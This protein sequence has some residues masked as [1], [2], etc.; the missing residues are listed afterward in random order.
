MRF[1][2][3]GLFLVSLVP[4]CANDEV[5]DASESTSSSELTTSESTTTVF[6]LAGT[7]G[8]PKVVTNFL[9]GDVTRGNTVVPVYYPNHKSDIDN[10]ML[11]GASILNEK[12]T[13]VPGKKIVFAHSLGAVM[14]SCWLRQYGPTSNVDP[15]ELEFILIGNSIRPYNGYYTLNNF[16]QTDGKPFVDPD[17]VSPISDT[18]YRVRDIAIQYDGWSDWPNLNVKESMDNAKWGKLIY[19]LMYG[20]FPLDRPDYVKYTEG[21]IT[22]TLIPVNQWWSSASSLAKIET[23]YQRPEPL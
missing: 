7:N 2:F 14:S 17:L 11:E 23:G 19:H 1:Q 10:D 18:R 5:L 8:D 13:T 20:R 21:N 9:K 12:L 22:Y 15:A 4:A 6:T 16:T 3:L